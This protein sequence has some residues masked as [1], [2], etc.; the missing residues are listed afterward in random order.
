MCDRQTAI[1]ADLQREIDVL[2]VELREEWASNHA[3]HCG[4]EWP[5]PD[6]RWCGWKMPAILTDRAAMVSTA[7]PHLR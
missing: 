7:P 5:H 4:S 1:I 2:R 3:E 6:Q